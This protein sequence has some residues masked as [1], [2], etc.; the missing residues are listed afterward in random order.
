MYFFG[1]QLTL[2]ACVRVAD[3]EVFALAACVDVAIDALLAL[4]Q[5]TRGIAVHAI[6]RGRLPGGP[7]ASVA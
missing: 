4:G 3:G 6:R 2:A 1:S 7:R 5:E